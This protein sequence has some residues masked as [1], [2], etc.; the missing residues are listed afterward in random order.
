MV[1]K[2]SKLEALLS[3]NRYRKRWGAAKY[4][5]LDQ[6]YAGMKQ[7]L[8]EDSDRE[9]RSGKQKSLDD[10]MANLRL[11][12]KGQPE[13]LFYHAQLI[14]LMRREYNVRETYQQF[15]TL[16]ENEAPFL[17]AHLDLRWLISA[18]DSIADLD[19]D[20]TA[21]A[22]A[23]IGSSLANTIKVYETDRFIHGGDERP[24]SQ[25]AIEQT[26]GAPMHRFNGM[27]L[28]KVGTDDT[29][30][31]MRW[32]LDPF[33]KQGIAGAIAKAIYDR[34]QENDT[35]FSRLRALHHRDRSGW[36]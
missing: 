31:N 28:F 20:L 9:H 19:E 33:F 13:L 17:T 11:E 22:I 14:V 5:K 30:R 18:S 16:W 26:Q 4:A 6:D 34:L 24:V 3:F 12:F 7:R 21:R 32:R 1:R 8:I 35:A 27:Y 36:W 25:E 2:K 10:H 23:M 15:K 29:L